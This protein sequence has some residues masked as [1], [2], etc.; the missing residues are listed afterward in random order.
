MNDG[1]P[2]E[3]KLWSAFYTKALG[4]AMEF[5]PTFPLQILENSTFLKNVRSVIPSEEW[6]LLKT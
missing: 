5:F 6:R 4:S 1:A 2:N 3:T